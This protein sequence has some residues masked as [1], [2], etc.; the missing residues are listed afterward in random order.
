MAKV[1][2]MTDNRKLSD[3]K[4]GERRVFKDIDNWEVVVISIHSGN[5]SFKVNWEGIYKGDI[6]IGKKNEIR[7]YNGIDKET[8]EFPYPHPVII[9]KNLKQVIKYFYLKAKKPKK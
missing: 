5:I 3:L 7:I 1:K 8:I 6:I 9:V 4:I 2:R